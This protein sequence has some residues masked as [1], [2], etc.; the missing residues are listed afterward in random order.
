MGCSSGEF[1]PGMYLH[2]T[3][4][5]PTRIPKHY[6][7][8]EKLPLLW[9]LVCCYV[10]DAK[11]GRFRRIQVDPIAQENTYSVLSPVPIGGMPVP[12]V[13]NVTVKGLYP[14]LRSTQCPGCLLMFCFFPKILQP[15]APQK[16][17]S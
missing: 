1:G 10:I 17:S 7:T 12:R 4:P 15:N 2:L 11:Q 8:M 14:G 6:L 13:A 9:V 5:Q 16:L 3:N